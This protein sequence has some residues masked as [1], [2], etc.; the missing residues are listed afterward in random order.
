MVKSDLLSVAKIEETLDAICRTPTKH[1]AEL[2][3]QVKLLVLSQVSYQPLT[4][5]SSLERYTGTIDSLGRAFR[6]LKIS[7]D[8]YVISLLE[9]N[10]DRSRRKLAE[11]RLNRKIWRHDQMKSF[12]ATTLKIC[13]EL[14]AWATDYYVSQVIAKVIKLAVEPG[15]SVGIWDLAAAE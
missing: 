9:E 10:T 7:E 12:Y 2:R 8:L 15:P 3:L 11:I 14:R 4:S 13:S 5:E 6:G 1:R